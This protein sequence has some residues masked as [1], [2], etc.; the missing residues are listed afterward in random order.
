MKM[1]WYTVAAAIGALAILASCSAASSIPTTLQV[2]VGGV[3]NIVYNN[4]SYSYNNGGAVSSF[5]AQFYVTNTSS[6]TPINVT[7]ITVLD[8]ANFKVTGATG[9][10]TLLINRGNT[11]TFY[12]SNNVTTPAAGP[13]TTTVRIAND[14]SDTT[15]YFQFSF[16]V[17]IS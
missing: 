3:T 17:T 6:T 15:P 14:A 11:I 5:R 9:T 8:P 12:I 4:G 1:K 13:Y 7:G 16:T 2:T 10:S